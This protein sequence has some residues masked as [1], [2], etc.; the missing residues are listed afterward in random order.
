MPTL[1]FVDFLKKRR[2][3]M[4]IKTVCDDRWVLLYDNHGNTLLYSKDEIVHC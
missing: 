2:I 4:K 3:E 1:I